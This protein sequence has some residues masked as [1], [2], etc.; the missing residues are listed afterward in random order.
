MEQVN[1]SELEALAAQILNEAE[2]AD[3]EVIKKA[4]DRRMEDLNKLGIGHLGPRKSAEKMAKDFQEKQGF[5]KEGIQ[6]MARDMAIRLIREKVPDIS[7]EHL[8]TLLAEWVPTD[9]EKQERPTKK[10]PTL[11]PEALLAMV[12]DFMD[13]AQGMMSPTKQV[14]LH[15]RLGDWQEQ[16]WQSFPERVQRLIHVVLKGKLEAGVFWDEVKQTLE[17]KR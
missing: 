9:T 2:F 10:A 13:F 6:G 5:S 4:C 3:I 14:E 12:K 17:G 1:R 8:K 7:E 15:D 16:F 11:P